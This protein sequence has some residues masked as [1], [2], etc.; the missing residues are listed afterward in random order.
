MQELVSALSSWASR[1]RQI[2]C[3]EAGVPL[4]CCTFAQYQP[5]DCAGP[6]LVEQLSLDPF[7]S[8]IKSRPLHGMLVVHTTRA[9]P[10][11]RLWC[12]HEI[13]EALESKLYVVA[14]GCY[15]LGGRTSVSTCDAKCG[16]AADEQ[17]IRAS[18]ESKDGSYDRLDATIRAFRSTMLKSGTSVVAAFELQRPQGNGD[19]D[20]V[21]WHKTHS[22]LEAALKEA[23]ELGIRDFD[24]FDLA[25]LV[26][27]QGDKIDFCLPEPSPRASRELPTLP[28][29][30]TGPLASSELPTLLESR[31]GPLASRGLPTPLGRRTEV[32]SM[33]TF[34][35]FCKS[36]PS[37]RFPVRL[38]VAFGIR[39]R[40]HWHRPDTCMDFHMDYQ[41]EGCPKVESNEDWSGPTEEIDFAAIE[42]RMCGRDGFCPSYLLMQSALS[43]QW[44]LTVPGPRQTRRGRIYKEV[45]MLFHMFCEDDIVRCDFTKRDLSCWR[46][47]LKGPSSTPYEGG[48]FAAEFQLP[49]DYPFQPPNHFK[50]LTKV[51]HPNITDNGEL[52][53]DFLEDKWSPAFH[54]F[55]MF[56]SILSLLGT[57]EPL[58][59]MN[60]E[61]AALQLNHPETFAAKARMWTRLYATPEPP[62][63]SFQQLAHSKRPCSLVSL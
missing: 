40:N 24:F 14:V 11:D 57:P 3:S 17:R 36:I 25:Q 27:K 49:Y 37:H 46:V 29:R 33:S 44:A 13:D 56:W 5:E 1:I 9:D 47:Y 4:W 31:R 8:V 22:K 39:R 23:T 61:A 20:A 58:D 26:D 50:I 38:D 45:V 30:G 6:S 42:R 28:G 16:H 60:V 59:P 48:W 34:F 43:G 53:V 55:S 18:I 51:L 54:L 10:Y 32:M 62:V 35:C 7:K 2:W 63:P 52:C 21:S 12:V 19:E 15:V 41:I